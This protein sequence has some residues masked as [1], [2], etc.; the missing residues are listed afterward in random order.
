MCL[1][2]TSWVFD[3]QTEETRQE[4]SCRTVGNWVDYFWVRG[5]QTFIARAP[6]KVFHER[7]APYHP[8]K[9]K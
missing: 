3:G 7:H 9:L 5:S 4:T 2:A 6:L 1:M 8:N